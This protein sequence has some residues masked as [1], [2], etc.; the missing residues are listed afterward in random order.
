MPM[1]QSLTSSGKGVG[2]CGHSNKAN[3]TNIGHFTR[4]RIDRH[5]TRAGGGW[6]HPPAPVE[7]GGAKKGSRG[8]ETNTRWLLLAEPW[9]KMEGW[10]THS[11][12][13]LL[14]NTPAHVP[15]TL[16]PHYLHSAKA[17]E[18]NKPP[19]TTTAPP[20]PSGKTSPSQLRLTKSDVLLNCTWYRRRPFS[21]KSKTDC[22]SLGRGLLDKWRWQSGDSEALPGLKMEGG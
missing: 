1:S 3:Y 2:W 6:M 18:R 11:Y 14:T 8:A 20:S 19:H 22:F 4:T 7:G 13:P 5:E 17:D 9:S 12:P 15:P 16:P 21:F 10:K